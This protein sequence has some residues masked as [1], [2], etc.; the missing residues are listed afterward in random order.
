MS[1]TVL[2]DQ[3]SYAYGT[4]RDLALDGVTFS[5]ERGTSLAVVGQTGSGKST[6]ARLACGLETPDEGHVLVEGIDTRDRR[7]RR[8][9]HGTVGYV[10]QRPERQLFAET[11]RADV[12]YGPSNQGIPKGEIERR[13]SEMLEYVGLADR[14][15]DSPFM[16]SGGQKR[17]CALAGVLAMDPSVL[18]MD[19]PTAGLDPRG[20]AEL[21]SIIARLHAEGVTILQVTHS[22]EDAAL[23]DRVL[24]LDQGGL[25]MEGTPAETFSHA[26]D[27]AAC[28]LGVPEPLAW[29]KDLAGRGLNGL[30]EPLSIEDLADAIAREVS[31][32]L[33][34]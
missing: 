13:V 27:L 14:A 31:G 17:L 10:M 6:L 2:F 5:V 12:A 22:M 26:E 30:G 4:S 20:R 29:A 7:G 24:V 16:L 1:A 23:A 25:L 21:R 19:E 18:V 33:S 32:C 8:A 9:L 3:V 34:R 28:G 15:D 11:V